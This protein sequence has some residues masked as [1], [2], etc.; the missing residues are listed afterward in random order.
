MADWTNLDRAFQLPDTVTDAK[1][2][3]LY[4][5]LRERLR[6][7]A[8]GTD[9]SIMQ[10]LQ[11]ERSIGLYIRG[12]QAEQAAYGEAGGFAHLSQEK[13]YWSAWDAA[14]SRFTEL[15]RKGKM[16]PVA[17]GLTPQQVRD[18]FMAV[19]ATVSDPAMRAELQD[20]FADALSGV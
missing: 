12:R 8:E 7:E 6:A 16:T 14:A 20:K 2:R 15:V 11:G 3:E 5:F 13:D 4:E 18:V 9:L 1:L 10:I 19:L 17:G